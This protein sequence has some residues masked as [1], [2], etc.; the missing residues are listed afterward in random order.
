MFGNN[1][2]RKEVEQYKNYYSEILVG[3]HTD[4]NQ[5][6]QLVDENSQRTEKLILEINRKL[7]IVSQ[8][9]KEVEQKEIS[10]KAIE[11]SVFQKEELI[12]KMLESIN[13]TKTDLEDFKITSQSICNIFDNNKNE[14]KALKRTNKIISICFSFVIILIIIYLMLWI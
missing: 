3:I 8:I 5:Y 10:I 9:K 6:K 14:I 7:E 1:N 11:K 13:S 12:S 4:L 2:L